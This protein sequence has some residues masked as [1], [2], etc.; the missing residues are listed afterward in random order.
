[1]FR[2]I[3]HPRS[4]RATWIVALLGFGVLAL[5]MSLVPMWE[6]VAF[7][8]AAASIAQK[9]LLN[10][11]VVEYTARTR[12]QKRLSRSRDPHAYAG[13]RHAQSMSYR[14]RLAQGSLSRTARPL[15][16]PRE[17]ASSDVVGRLMGGASAT[18]M[19]DYFGHRFSLSR[20][21]AP[22][23]SFDVADCL[24][25]L[26]RLGPSQAHAE[27]SQARDHVDMLDPPSTRMGC[28]TVSHVAV[29]S[30]SWSGPKSAFMIRTSGWLT[31]RINDHTRIAS[32]VKERNLTCSHNLA[33]DGEDWS[34]VLNLVQQSSAEMRAL[35]HTLWAYFGLSGGF[36]AYLTPPQAQGLNLH[37]DA[38]D[39]FV[40][41][42]S[43]KKVWTLHET[44]THVEIC[45]VEL[46][47]GDVLYVPAGTPHYAVSA[48][49]EPS[50]HLAVSVYRGYFTASGL[51]AAWLVLGS[52]TVVA[53]CSPG[54]AD[55]VDAQQKRLS[56]YGGPWDSNNQL[57][58]HSLGID[59]LRAFDPTDLPPGSHTAMASGLVLVARDLA[60]RMDDGGD[61]VDVDIAA[62]LRELS[63][64]SDEDQVETLVRAIFAARESRWVNHYRLH[65]PK[66]LGRKPVDVESLPRSARF[67]RCADASA[68]ASASGDLYINGYRVSGFVGGK[69]SACSFCMGLHTGA[70]GQSF[71]LADIPA[72]GGE[73]IL[74]AQ[75]LLDFEGL[76]VL[77]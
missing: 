35:H 38:A 61:A 39:V 17:E 46:S 3:R 6:P 60:A 58:P 57:L 77:T 2:R 59:V 69:M 62:K 40:L 43:G 75:L 42:Q 50:L 33:E 12:L 14:H 67:R 25:L 72:P 73:S 49:D 31:D 4:A 54:A 8:F 5:S 28:W 74:A 32:F 21:T 41:Q 65:Q 34:Y 30:A 13:N 45:D 48:G 20:S 70:S 64:R 52:C 22:R 15:A 56:K 47:R 16:G 11:R 10:D 44:G 1:M 66:D 36:N 7:I 63:N 9:Q 37:T 71:S 51:L 76:E 53:A 55:K 19:K 29:T 18:F 68:M 23:V 26:N 27:C 24:S